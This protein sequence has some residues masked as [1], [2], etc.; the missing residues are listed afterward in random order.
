MAKSTKPQLFAH[1]PSNYEVRIFCESIHY[2]ISVWNVPLPQSPPPIIITEE[3]DQYI[4]YII[5]FLALNDFFKNVIYPLEVQN[6]LF[7]LKG[8]D[9]DD[10]KG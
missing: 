9:F 7:D 6:I 5:Y 2:Q 3:Y 10:V 8:L 1:P 4:M